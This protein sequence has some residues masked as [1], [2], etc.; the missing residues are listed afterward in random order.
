MLADFEPKSIKEAYRL[1][2]P[3]MPFG[4]EFIEQVVF[5]DVNFGEPTK[6]GE[7]FT[8]WQG[9]KSHGLD[10]SSADIVGKYSA[11]R[12]MIGNDRRAS[13]MH[14]IVKN[15]TVMTRPTSSIVSI[16]TGSLHRKLCAFGCPTPSLV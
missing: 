8:P 6:P 4:F 9:N 14:L 1:K 16:Y 2:A 11:P 3:D 13:F 12:A 7:Q 15:V 10:L 5:R